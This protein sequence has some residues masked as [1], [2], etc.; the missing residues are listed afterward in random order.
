MS[1]A[2]RQGRAGGL[3]ERVYRRNFLCF[4]LDG[5][6]F[7]VAMGIVGTSTVIPDF[8]RRLTDSEILIGLS[9]NLF[10]A[11]FALPQLFVARIIVRSARK[12]LWF[13]LPNIPTRFIILAFAILMYLIGADHPDL[14]L[15]AFFLCYSVAALGDGLVGIPWADM[16]GSSLDS[17]W[18]ARL[19]GLMSGG[20]GLIMLGVVPLVALVL[21]ERGPGFPQNYALLFGVSG[22]LFALS[23]LPVIF[24][25]ELPGASAVKKA[26]N[27]IEY[28]PQLGFLV[29]KD[30]QYRAMLIIRMLTDLFLMA[31]PFYIGFATVELGLSSEVAVPGLLAMQTLGTMGGALLY[32]WLGAR[33]NVLYLRLALMASVLLP[34]SALLASTLGPITL[35]IGFLVSGLATSNLF[36]GFQ[37]WLVE[38]VVPEEL[39]ACVGLSNTLTAFV[40]LI[41]PVIGGSIAHYAGFKTLFSVSLLLALA[42]LFVI[43]RYIRQPDISR[44]K[45][46]AGAQG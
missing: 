17:R 22:V 2:T 4:T 43:L 25:R 9:G 11:G 24:V 35:S 7:M 45:V 5:V 33:N 29:R 13:V 3:R 46:A 16:A 44:R 30:S 19:Y 28:L 6:L 41:A 31:T 21:S 37:N 10:T 40:V 38:H 14:I 20:T 42:A 8:V 26:P 23:I 1:T 36:F 15:P 18:R 12:K 34:L 27:F 32:M 39:P